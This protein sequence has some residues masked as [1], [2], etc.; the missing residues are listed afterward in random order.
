[1]TWKFQLVPVLSN[2]HWATDVL[3]GA[4][5]GFLSA[6]TV[7]PLYPALINMLPPRLVHQLLLVPT[8]VPGTGTARAFRP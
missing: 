3:A 7:W 8:Y 5:I 1:M 6:E 2:K 4:A